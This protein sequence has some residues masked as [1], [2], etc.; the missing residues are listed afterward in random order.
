M[1][2]CCYNRERCY[3]MLAKERQK[4]QN[5]VHNRSM[6]ESHMARHSTEDLW[7]QHCDSAESL[8]SVSSGHSAGASSFGQTSPGVGQSLMHLSQSYPYIPL[9]EAS[10][11]V[12]DPTPRSSLPMASLDAVPAGQHFRG[13]DGSIPAT[14]AVMQHDPFSFKAD[15]QLY[16]H[17]ALRQDVRVESSRHLPDESTTAVHTAKTAQQKTVTIGVSYR[18]NCSGNTG[19][20]SKPT[21]LSATHVNMLSPEGGGSTVPERSQ[22]RLS[23]PVP[24]TALSNHLSNS[25]S[26]VYINPQQAWLSS[27]QMPATYVSSLSSSCECLPSVTGGSETPVYLSS[28]SVSANSASGVPACHSS[29]LSRLKSE[30][31]DNPE[32]AK[33]MKCVTVTLDYVSMVLL[34]KLVVG[35][36]LHFC[37]TMLCK[38]G[39]CRHAAC[40]RVC[41]CLSHL[42]I[43]SKRINIISSKKF[44]CQVAKPF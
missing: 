4:Y 41:V 44:H 5:M 26:A 19:E 24:P 3:E 9:S 18:V 37:R 8:S 1:L 36:L 13:F 31:V 34:I 28:S 15:A 11:R 38:C 21:Y 23:D 14:A 32:Y 42:G 16:Q 35:Y 27:P 33:G 10:G 17:N 40:V 30:S 20:R 25:Y 39:L 43:L 29:N 22:N 12:H 6:A 7:Q 2:Q